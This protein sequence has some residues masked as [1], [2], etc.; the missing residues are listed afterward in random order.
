[1]EKR[2]Y[3]D[4][5]SKMAW[6]LQIKIAFIRNEAI[7]RR[8]QTVQNRKELGL[9]EDIN[10]RRYIMSRIVQYMQEGLIKEEAVQR[11]MEEE[12]ETVQKFK[13]LEN[14]GLNLKT[15]FII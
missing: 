10:N 11:V 6:D 5:R 9:D 13:Y 7:K 1:M 3:R 8:E 4:G 15:V 2:K 12:K 14:A